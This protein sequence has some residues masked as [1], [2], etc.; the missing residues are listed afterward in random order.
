MHAKG[1]IKEFRI[2]WIHYAV[3]QFYLYLLSS[4]MRTLE[5]CFLCL[6]IFKHKDAPLTGVR[7]LYLYIN[8]SVL[9]WYANTHI[10]LL[11]Y[12]SKCIK[13]YIITL[14]GSLMVFLTSGR[15]SSTSRTNSLPLRDAWY[16]G[17][18][19]CWQQKACMC[20]HNFHNIR[21]I[22]C[23]HKRLVWSVK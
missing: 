10:T 3:F 17:D 6:N 16:R 21:C 18:R 1:S 4:F 23:I 14:A 9:I 15:L 5:F 20:M 11:K 22:S 8:V 2:V 12:L 13:V 7:I 19:P